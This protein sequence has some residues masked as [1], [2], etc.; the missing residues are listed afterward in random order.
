MCTTH[1]IRH[2][3]QYQNPISDPNL[4]HPPQFDFT[5]LIWI[6]LIV[7]IVFAICGLVLFFVRNETVHVIYAGIG[8]IIF[9]IVS[10]AAKEYFESFFSIVIT[11]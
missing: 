8:T 6:M 2:G 3:T 10:K 9:M 11:L 4:F 5:K 1:D 7:G